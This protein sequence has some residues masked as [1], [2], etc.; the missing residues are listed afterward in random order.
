MLHSSKFIS[1]KVKI[2]VMQNSTFL[3]AIVLFTASCLL[4]LYPT[5]I[6][7]SGYDATYVL[8]VKQK[9]AIPENVLKN[10]YVGFWKKTYTW[11]SSGT[12]SYKIEKDP[13]KAFAIDANSGLITI[14]DPTRINGKIVRQDTVI[15]LIIRTTD[16]GIGYELDTAQI[17]IKE[18][19]YCIFVD[20]S[21]A[22]GT[23]TRTSPKNDLDNLTWSTGKMV[24]IKRGNIIKDETT[25]LATLISTSLHP[26]IIC[27]Y[28]AGNKPKFSG[29]SMSTGVCWSLVATPSETTNRI[30]YLYFYDLWIRAYPDAAYKARRADNNIGWYNCET[31]NCNRRDYE[32]SMVIN[33][34]SYA[35]STLTIPFEIINYISD[36]TS[37]DISNYDPAIPAKE[38][39]H[40][41]CQVSLNL[42]NCYFGDSR[43]WGVRLAGGKGAVIKHCLFNNKM[44]AVSGLNG[45][46]YTLMVRQNHAVIEDC[47]FMDLSRNAVIYLTAAGDEFQ[48]QSDYTKIKNCYLSGAS[49]YGLWYD[50]Q[51]ASYTPFHNNI[52]EDNYITNSPIGIMMEDG[53][54][55]NIRRNIIA[56]GS[57][58]GIKTSTASVGLSIC[59]NIVYGFTGDAISL[60]VGSGA[61]VYNNTVDGAINCTGS[62][63]STVKNNLYKVLAG[64]V[65]QTNNLDLDDISVTSYFESYSGHKYKLLSTAANAINKGA[66][67]GIN[68]DYL[69]NVISG[70]PDIGAYEYLSAKSAPENTTPVISNQQFMI[71]Q[72]SFN[73]L[74][75]G[76]VV[77]TDRDSGQ[78]LHYSI[79]SGNESGKFTIDNLTGIL[80]STT[81]DLFGSTTTTYNLTIKVADNA[82]VSLSDTAI[83]SVSFAGIPVAINN[84]PLVSDQDF[85]VQ[86][87]NFKNLLVGYIIAADN[88]LNQKITYSI[89]SG[90]ESGLFTLNPLNG[91]LKT[92][93]SNV[94]KNQPQ[95]HTLDIKVTDDAATPLST[96]ASVHIAFITQEKVVHIDPS[97]SSTTLAD[98]SLDHPYNSWKEVE[99]V[100]GSVYLQKKGTVALEESIMLGT[101]N[102]TLDAYGE[103]E[104]PIISG[105][106]NAYVISGYDKADV[107]VKNLHITGN[108]A[109]S[110]LYFIGDSCDNI[111]VEHCVLEN[112]AN[113]IRITNGKICNIKYNTIKSENDGIY[114]DAEVINVYYN[115]FK[116][117]RTGLNIA[118]NLSRANIYNNV[119]IDNN[120]SV[121]DTY[122]ELTLFNNI[123]YLSDASQK[124]IR[125]GSKKILSDHNIFYPEQEGFIEISARNY[126]R[127]DKLQQELSIDMNSFT[128][129]PMF[130][131]LIK[132]NFELE[133]VSPAINSG[134]NLNILEDYFGNSVPKSGRPDIGICEFNGKIEYPTDLI[135]VLSVYPNPSSGIVNVNIEA[136]DP[137]LINAY[138]NNTNNNT[139]IKVIDQRGV[140]IFSKLLDLTTQTANENF[141]LSSVPNGLYIIMFR[142]FDRQVVQKLVLNH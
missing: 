69:G 27:A 95:D 11:A 77:A 60:S 48:M 90:N 114:A 53:Y 30:E 43:G 123:F 24:C 100:E 116:N 85:I 18:N 63:S 54:K 128:E 82:E 33:T 105:T 81:A 41:K 56:N 15:N 25:T 61:V 7:A 106:T 23:G 29:A 124:A 129:N 67:I 136:N 9:Y 86:Q 62:S 39:S 98:G 142:Y 125:H 112:A 118:G 109:Q 2:K 16:S 117:N 37:N 35:D 19:S 52:I 71:N 91:E 104:L 108:N 138:S 72:S 119:F 68:T 80:G 88:D 84:P 78:V 121:S 47:R 12:I 42:I 44:S 141:D 130:V 45:Y 89:V 94:F 76:Q 20:Y 4:Y 10:D 26:L 66:N 46:A 97:I 102:I 14:L 107:T 6:F 75:I 79:E 140:T 137:Q 70:M 99:W 64:T 115:V 17:W 83:V 28:G 111:T 31:Y 13:S 51:G 50:D 5:K 8:A 122:A 133:N 139:E 127:L 73:N 96:T 113:A 36:T 40:I 134:I 58:N 49:M 57:G 65:T 93:I 1:L 120:E 38:P 3:R 21:A 110:C 103:G 32:S 101:G 92:T 55:N 22:N 132:E 59:H 126:S 87:R 34:S 135:P 131:D 74:I